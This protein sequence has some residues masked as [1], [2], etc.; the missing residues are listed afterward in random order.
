M[1]TNQYI[2]N[3]ITTSWINKILTIDAFLHNSILIRLKCACKNWLRVDN[4]KSFID[5]YHEIIIR[6]IK[7]F[8]DIKK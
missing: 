1:T 2:I 5:I 3:Y 7:F 8:K 4:G 6:I